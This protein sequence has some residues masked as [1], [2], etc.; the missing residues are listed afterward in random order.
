MC[1]LG[2]QGNLS[3]R[4]E[5]RDIIKMKTTPKMISPALFFKTIESKFRLNVV[6]NA[7]S[8]IGHGIHRN[9]LHCHRSK[10]MPLL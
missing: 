5:R 3:L 8:V 1:I 10:G 7:E 2:F 9:M 6:L 4:C